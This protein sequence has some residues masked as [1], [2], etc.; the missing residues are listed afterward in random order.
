MGARQ[1][2]HDAKV[3]DALAAQGK[4]DAGQV[5]EMLGISQ[6]S[7]RRL[8][9]RLEGAGK[10]IRTHGGIQM[11]NTGSQGYSFEALEGKNLPEKRR[12][13]EYAA[14]LIAD[15]DILY[16]DGG[17]TLLQLAAALRQR[18]QT[19]A[20]KRIRV[21][22]NSLANL[23]ALHENCEVILIGGAFR[24]ERKD[25]AGYAAE[26]FVQ[27]FNYRKA[28]LGAD[29]FDLAEGFMA[30]DADTARLNELMMKR[31][32]DAYVLMDSGKFGTRS[33]VSYGAAGDA[34]AI[35][36]DGN[37]PKETEEACAR[38]GVSLLVAK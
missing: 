17:T 10:V 4:L 37:L 19:G 11:A 14:A 20:L 34:R 6:S 1:Q 31:A 3:L 5:M 27:H 32:Q 16:L 24:P 29:G 12:I 13:A 2:D 21:V 30:T 25:F 22:T 38:A 8:F 9:L 15:G 7:V 36:T 35:V 23:L 33:F 26:R 18:L 28:F